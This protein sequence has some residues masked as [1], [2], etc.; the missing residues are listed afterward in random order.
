[1]CMYQTC[2]DIVGPRP[3]CV[4]V[5]RVNKSPLVPVFKGGSHLK[6]TKDVLQRIPDEDLLTAIQWKSYECTKKKNP[7]FAVASFFTSHTLNIHWQ[8][9][10]CFF[11]LCPGLR[12]YSRSSIDSHFALTVQSSGH[13]CSC[14][15]LHFH[16]MSERKLTL[17]K[18]RKEFRP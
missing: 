16:F 9:E 10:F 4:G 13:L 6:V 5:C 15:M 17:Y 12:S 18:R 3:R 2:A 8:T 14:F 7:S 11:F 1:M